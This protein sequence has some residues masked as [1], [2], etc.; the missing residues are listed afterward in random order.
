MKQ[1]P[2]GGGGTHGAQWHDGKLWIIASR[3]N[4]MLRVDPKAWTCDYAIR[5]RNDTPD[6]MRSHDMTFDDQGF[7]WL[8]TA[9]NSKSYAEGV[10]G[11][12]KYDPRTG[13]VLEQ[14]TLE[15]GSCDPHGLGL[16][17]RRLH[18]LRCRPS[19][20]LAGQG[21]SRRG[22]DLPDRVDLTGCASRHGPISQP[23][24]D[25]SPDQIPGLSRCERYRAGR[26][27]PSVRGVAWKAARCARCALVYSHKK[28][29]RPEKSTARTLRGNYA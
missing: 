8:A 3:L 21:W 27:V 13:E 26:F 11:L 29:N 1:I 22:L 24:R 12:S 6:T 19:S 2:L 23:L 20:G 5:I 28:P 4:C 14:V 15:P 10:Q 25:F 18:R 7:I 17:Q 9:N 16:L